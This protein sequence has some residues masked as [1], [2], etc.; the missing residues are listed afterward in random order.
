MKK[1]SNDNIFLNSMNDLTR[2]AYS[3]DNRNKPLNNSPSITRLESDLFI[4]KKEEFESNNSKINSLHDEIREL[5]SKL[6]LIEEKDKKI[7]EL[8]IE[9]EKKD[10][11]IN[12]LNNTIRGL[13]D[14]QTEIIRLKNENDQYQFDLMNMKSIQQ[15][16]QLLSEKLIELTKQTEN[17]EKEEIIG[18]DENRIKIDIDKIKIILNNR[19][20]TYQ[21]DHIQK[22]I[23]EYELSNKEYISKDILSELLSKA[24]HI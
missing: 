2:Q 1:Y 6:T 13:K 22:I 11:E 19:L 8:K 16:N 7:Y 10:T 17:K 12:E 9:I 5:K 4:T 21:E 20:K 15:R 3:Q 14:N 24:I 23:D 18:K